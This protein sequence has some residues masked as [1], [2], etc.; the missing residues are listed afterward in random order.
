MLGNSSSGAATI[1]FNPLIYTGPNLS[2]PRSGAAT[3]CTRVFSQPK[4][5]CLESQVEERR[6]HSWPASSPNLG[7]QAWHFVSF[8]VLYSVLG[9]GND[10]HHAA[11]LSRP[12]AKLSCS[13]FRFE[14]WQRLFQCRPF[15]HV[16]IRARELGSPTL[17]NM[18][19]LDKIVVRKTVS[20][21][22]VYSHIVARIKI[23]KNQ[24]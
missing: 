18:P 21:T 3:C 23:P 10:S 9:S 19:A 17:R 2:A 1:V 13:V 15:M 14:E 11:H 4:L 6:R 8:H 20:Y 5:S 16:P 22:M 7:F 12:Q 24:N